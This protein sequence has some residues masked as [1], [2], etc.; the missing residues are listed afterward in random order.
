MELLAEAAIIISTLSAILFVIIAI[1]VYID[2]LPGKNYKEESKIDRKL[3]EWRNYILY[4][5][6]IR[7]CMRHIGKEIK[8]T[9][10]KNK[11]I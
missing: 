10:K 1:Y 5:I 3:R 6:A 11:R 9:D 8:K 4:R 7:R 2:N